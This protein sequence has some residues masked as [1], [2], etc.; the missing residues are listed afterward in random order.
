MFSGTSSP[1]VIDLT[2]EPGRQATFRDGNENRVGAVRAA[3][4]G[5]KRVAN[6]ARRLATPSFPLERVDFPKLTTGGIVVGMMLSP[7]LEIYV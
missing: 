6:H 7:Q 5:Q 3:V 1:N 2:G 4:T